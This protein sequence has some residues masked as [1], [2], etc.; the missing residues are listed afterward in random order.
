MVA[1]EEIADQLK[2]SNGYLTLY[3]GLIQKEKI[4]AERKPDPM[5]QSIIDAAEL[6][7]RKLW[8]ELPDSAKEDLSP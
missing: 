8:L 1:L 5:P 4:L 6:F 7:A 2:R 3:C